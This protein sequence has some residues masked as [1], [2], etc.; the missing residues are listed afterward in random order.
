MLLNSNAPLSESDKDLFKI[1]NSRNDKALYLQAYR[2]LR[3]LIISGYFKNGEKLMSEAELANLMGIGRTSLRTALVLLSEDGYIKTFQGKGTYIVYDSNSVSPNEYPDKYLLP[4]ERLHSIAKGRSIGSIDVGQFTTDYDAFLD[5]VL[6]A[7]KN[8]INLFMRN[9]T[10]DHD[11]AVVSNTYYQSS[12]LNNIDFNDF[13]RTEALLKSLFEE[14]VCSVDASISPAP[15]FESR[16]LNRFNSDNTNFILV[17]SI[18]Y[19]SDHNPI[20]FTKDHY[21]GDYISFNIHYH[22]N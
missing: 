11:V 9:Y 5:D 16:K 14:Q 15:D 2:K 6:H 1:P 22:K 7:D 8:P 21:S 12:L 17:S 20:V 10:I 13:D 18:W 4:L 19:D 3:E